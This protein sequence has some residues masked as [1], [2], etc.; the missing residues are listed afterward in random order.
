M[1]KSKVSDHTL[2]TAGRRTFIKTLGSVIATGALGSTAPY[3]FARQKT[4]LRILGTHVTLQ[5][6]L[7]QQAMQDIGIDLVFEPRGSAAVLQKASVSPSSFDLYEQWSNSIRP[8]W[9]SGSIQAI[10]KKRL[11]YWD[12]INPLSKT[13]KISPDAKIGAGDAPNKILNIQAD[14][15]LGSNPTELISFLP[16]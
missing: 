3:V 9:A 7:R 13:G 8:L 6:Q 10:E 16:Y 15:T 14:G 11:T 4:R 2:N 5:E 12:E 1:R